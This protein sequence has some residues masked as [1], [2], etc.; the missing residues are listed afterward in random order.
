MVSGVLLF[1]LIWGLV[2]VLVRV[3][4]PGQNIMTKKETGEKKVYSA[5][6]STLLL[7]TKGSQDW[8]SSGSE[9][10]G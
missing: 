8:N 10:R 9:S 4:I 2:Y 5:Y 6:I 7:I 3:S 1:F